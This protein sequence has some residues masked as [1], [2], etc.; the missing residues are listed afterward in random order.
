MGKLILKAFINIRKAQI[1]CTEKQN[2]VEKKLEK[3]IELLE[4]KENHEK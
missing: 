4:E 1:V 2:E 3:I